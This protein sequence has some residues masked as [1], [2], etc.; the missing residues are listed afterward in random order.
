MSYKHITREERNVI[1]RMQFLG[2]SKKDIAEALDRNRSTLHRELKRNANSD[3]R[4][5]PVIADILARCRRHLKIRHPKTGKKKLMKYVSDHL[6]K[7]WSPEQISGRIREIDHSDDPTMQIS[8]STI[9]R[10]IWSDPER[11]RQF[12]PH[13]RHAWRKRRKRYGIPSNRGQIKDRIFID[14]RPEIVERRERL[15]DWEADTVEG[16]NH[17][18]YI[19]TCV[20]RASCYLLA[21]KL[22]NKKAKTLTA[23]ILSAFQSIADKCFTLTVDNG[24][25]FSD[26]KT[27]SERLKAQVYFAHPFSCWERGTNENTNGL[28][29]QFIPKGT[30][31]RD[32]TKKQL[33]KYIRKLNNRP[34]KLLSYRTPAEVFHQRVLHLRC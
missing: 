13:M 27:I 16:R 31:I 28:L 26:H 3:G 4:Y 8:H 10:W 15:G 6:E 5:F 20:D 32:I 30:D 24:K 21:R 1:Y 12:R 11:S 7:A 2:Y 22:A 34:R 17:K 14:E 23:A 18:G 25:E 29:R 33:A 19:A 9:Y